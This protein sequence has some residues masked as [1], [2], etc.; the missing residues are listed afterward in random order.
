M[1]TETFSKKILQK[2]VLIPAI[3]GAGIL[4]SAAFIVAL[5]TENSWAQQSGMRWNNEFLHR[6]YKYP[7]YYRCS[8]CARPNS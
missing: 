8:N 2:K 7:V 6:E 5:P 4:L 1:E 3:I